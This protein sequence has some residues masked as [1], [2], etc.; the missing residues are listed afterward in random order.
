LSCRLPRA[1]RRL[2]LEQDDRFDAISLVAREV[3]DMED[4][5]GFN[6]RFDADWIHG[7]TPFNPFFD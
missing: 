1:G 6:S 5:I 2:F 4:A 7:S 3:G